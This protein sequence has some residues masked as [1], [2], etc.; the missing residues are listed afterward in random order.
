V[1]WST[2]HSPRSTAV[3]AR[4]GLSGEGQILLLGVKG[5]R[6]TIRKILIHR[7]LQ[8]GCFKP[9]FTVDCGLWTVDCDLS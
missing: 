2:D 4:P 8:T 6:R 5:M 1:K 7:Q 3:L 9:V